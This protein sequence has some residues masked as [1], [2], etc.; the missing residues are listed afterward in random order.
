MPNRTG[1][2]MPPEIRLRAITKLRSNPSP[3]IGES[4]AET[5]RNLP[6]PAPPAQR[7]NSHVRER[8]S[9]GD[10]RLPGGRRRARRAITTG[11][12]AM[13]PSRSEIGGMTS[14]LAAPNLHA[15]AT[16]QARPAHRRAD[17][18]GRPDI[19]SGPYNASVLSGP[20]PVPTGGGG[21][22]TPAARTAGPTLIS[23]S[24]P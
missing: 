1:P 15:T 7:R 2:P 9:V 3:K 20:T 13:E 17:R 22:C 10:T 12:T 5:S 19:P 16:R 14:R 23:L 11:E 18:T 4:L 21:A 8:F 24:A 6:C